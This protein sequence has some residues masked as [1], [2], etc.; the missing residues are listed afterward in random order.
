VNELEKLV[1]VKWE[2]ELPLTIHGV[3]I[4]ADVLAF[5]EG[6]AVAARVPD[7]ATTRPILQLTRPYMRG[8]DVR[9]LQA[10]LQQQ[11][12][13][14]DQ[15]GVLGPMTSVLVK[16]FQAKRSLPADGVVGPATW[17]ALEISVGAAAR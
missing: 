10:A 13:S 17:Q 9:A 7:P 16:Q 12:F 5:Y 15:D 1:G 4:I 8:D 2:L 14:G 3:V 11:G 6:P